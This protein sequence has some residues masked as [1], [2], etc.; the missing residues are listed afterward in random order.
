MAA[1]FEAQVDRDAEQVACRFRGASLTYGELDRRANQLAR[2]LRALGVRDESCV[3]VHLE[4]SLAAVVAIVAVVKAGGAYVPLDPEHPA[5]RCAFTIRDSGA[6]VVVT[7]RSLWRGAAVPD[8]PAV[9]WLD[10]AD[11]GLAAESPERLPLVATPESLAYVI[12][13]SGSTGAPKGV[14]VTHRNA[15]RL[16][17]AT[18]AWFGFGAADVW[19]LF[20]SLAFDFSVWELWG[21][22][23]YGGTVVI[24]PFEVSRSPRQMARLLAEEGVTVLNQTPSAFR[25][26]SPALLAEGGPLALRTIIFGGEALDYRA[27]R[28]WVARHGDQTPRLVNMYGITE[29]TVHVTY[30]P[31]LAGDVAADTPSCIGAPIPDLELLLLD[32]HLAPVADGEPGEIFVAGPGVARGYLNRP[33]LT[34]ERF[35]EWNGRRV[36]RSGDRARRLAD[37]DLEYL[38]RGD[39]Q[40]KLRGFRIETGEIAARLGEVEGVRE[41]VVRLVGAGDAARLVAY[42]VL[43]DGHELDRAAARRRLRT[44]LPDPMIP[45]AFV[46]LRAWPL[47]ING[48]LDVAALPLPERE[49]GE[50]RPPTGETARTIAALWREVLGVEQVGLG[51]D[52]VAL[53][54]ASLAAAEVAA[55]IA[56]ALGVA[57]SLRQV[58]EHTRLE[59]L[60][61]F[62]EAQARPAASPADGATAPAATDE[63]SAAEQAFF[64]M[65]QRAPGLALYAESL[66]WRWRGPFD[67]AL[68]RE[69]LDELARRHPIL[70]TTFVMAADGPRR[71]IAAESSVELTAHDLTHLEASQREAHARSAAAIRLRDGFDLE[72]GPLWR[73]LV[74]SAADEAPTIFILFHH[75]ILD[76]VACAELVTQLDA[77]YRALRAGV[78]L[79]PPPRVRS[80]AGEAA[81]DLPFWRAQL[82]DLPELEVPTDRSRPLVPSFRGGKVSRVVPAALAHEVRALSRQAGVTPFTTLLAAFELLL[83]RLC[84]A[85]EV[86][87]GVIAAGRVQRGGALGCF[88]NPLVVRQELARDEPFRELLGRAR[89]TLLDAQ[90][91]PSL[92]FARLVGE[93]GASRID[94]RNPLFQVAFSADVPMPA[95]ATAAGFE[96]GPLDP[97]TARFDLAVH[98]EER[99]DTFA[100][101]AEYASDLFDEVTVARWLERYV[102]VLEGVARE[103]SVRVGAVEI[104]G[105]REKD[106]LARFAAGP[107]APNGPG[108]PERLRDL[109]RES[110][111]AL[112]VVSGAA[113]LTYGELAARAERIAGH[114][115]S[116][117]VE[118]DEL[119]GLY[120]RPN[121]EWVAAVFGIWRAGAAYVPLDPRHPAERIGTTLADAGVRR[122]ITIE[123]A[124]SALTRFD[125]HVL[126][127]E[128]LVADPPRAAVA[129]SDSRGR[130]AYV[131]YTSGSTGTPKGALVGHDN[132]ANFCDGFV[133]LF[134]A[135]PGDRVAQLNSPAFDASVLE[136]LLALTTG[137]TLVIAP[138]EARIP[139]AE[140][141]EFLAGQG[142]SLAF[143]APALFGALP[144]AQP[145]SALPRLRHVLFGGDVLSRELVERWAPGRTVWNAY[146][147]TETTVIT[148]ATRVRADGSRPPIGRP[149]AGMRAHVVDE[150]LRPCPIGVAGELVIGGAGVGRGY[151]RRPELTQ[152]RFL[153]DPFAADAGARIYRSGDLVRL[154]SDGQIEFLSRLDRQVKLRGNRIELG[155]IESVLVGSP[156]VAQAVVVARVDQG[157]MRLVAYVVGQG[158]PIDPS[159][160]RARLRER[161]PEFMVPAAF[162]ELERLPLNTSGKLDLMAL[163]SPSAAPAPRVE[164]A[165]RAPRDERLEPVIA[166]L[167]GE[168]LGLAA[169]PVDVPFFEL[170]GNSL[171]LVRVQTGLRERF[172]R[173]VSAVQLLALPTVQAIAGHLR[174]L[175]VDDAPRAIGSSARSA[176]PAPAARSNAIAIVGRFVR[177]PG[178]ETLA[179]LWRIVA[180]GRDVIEPFA[181]GEV[182]A[183]GEHPHFVAAE[184][185]LDGANAF[186]AEFFGMTPADARLMD[187]QHRVFLEAAWASLEDAGHDPRRFAGRIGVF[188]G[189]GVPRHWLGPIG[190]ALREDP[191]AALADRAELF[192]LPEHLTSRTAFKLGLRGPA[193]TVHAACATSLVAVHMACRSLLA[194][195]CEMALAGGV[196]ISTVAPSERGYMA[197][198]GGIFSPTGRCRPFSLDADGTVKASGVGVVVLRRLEDAI[199]AGDA[200]AGVILGSAVNNDGGASVGFS[201]PAEAG[202][203]AVLTEAYRAA[204]VAPTEVDLVEAHGTGTALGDATEVSALRRVFGATRTAE[205]VSLGSVK[206][207]LGHLDS[208]AGVVGLIKATLALEHR[209][210]PGLPEFRG[211][212]PLLEIDA[213]P[214]V[215]HGEPRPLVRRGRP[216][217]AGVT[218][219]GMGGNNAHVVV[220]EAPVTAAQPAARDTA[221]L[222]CL[223]ARTPAALDAMTRRLA[224]HLR[225]EPRASVDDVAFTLATGRAELPL[226]RAV[227]V[228]A[229]ED[230][231]AALADRRAWIDGSAAGGRPVVFLFPGH[232]AQTVG[233]GLDLYRSEPRYREVVDRCLAL[234]RDGA[235]VDLGP[236]LLTRDASRQA[237]F[238]EPR[239]GQLG[240]FVVG[241]ALA[242]LLRGW[243]VAPAALLGHSLGEYVAACVAG[244]FSL[245]DALALV[246]ARARLM[247]GCGPGTMVSI[248]AERADVAPI[249]PASVS[250][251]TEAPGCTVI[252]GPVEAVAAVEARLLARGFEATRLPVTQAYHSPMMAPI[253]EA[254]LARVAAVQR[255]PPSLPVLSCVTGEWLTD[256]A[257][258]DP[259][260]WADHLCG[261]VTLTGALGTLLADPARV[262]VE[263]GPGRSMRGFLRRHP[264]AGES[265]VTVTTLRHASEPE[266]ADDAHLLAGVGRL[267]AHGVALDWPAVHARRSARRVPLPTY[268]FERRVHMIDQS[269]MIQ[270]PARA[271]VFSLAGER[272]ALELQAS[273]LERELGVRTLD[274]RPGVREG[275]EAVALALVGRYFVEHG[276]ARPGER[277]RVAALQDRLGVLPRFERMFAFLLA[278]SHARG[279]CEVDAGAVIWRELPSAA[280]AE[281][282]FLRRHPEFAGLVR[283]VAHAVGHYHA[284]FRGEVESIGVLYPDGS[285]AFYR[286]CMRASAPISS[287]ELCLRLARSVAVSLVNSRSEPTRILEVG[288][289]HG[290]LTWPLI[291]ELV[292]CVARGRRVDYSFT[293]IGRSFLARA[294][295]RAAERGAAFVRTGRYDLDREPASQG[296]AP[297]SFDLIL[298]FNAVHTARDTAATVA[299]LHELLAPRGLLVLV[300]ATRVE[301]WETL[302]WGLAPGFWDVMERGRESLLHRAEDW[303]DFTRRAGFAVTELLPRAGRGRHD[304]A[305]VVAQRAAVQASL[306][307]SEASRV[308]PANRPQVAARPDTNGAAVQ[309]AEAV[310]AKIFHRLLGTRDVAPDASF[311]ALGGDSLLAVQLLAEV[312]VGLGA[313]VRSSEFAQAPTIAGLTRLVAPRLPATG[314]RAATRTEA[315]GSEARL[316]GAERGTS[317][318]E[319]VSLAARLPRALAAT[320]RDDASLVARSLRAEHATA[321]DDAS[322]AA[323]SPHVVQAT[324]RHDASLAARSPHVVQATTRHDASLAARSP[325]VVQA[326]TRHDAS[327][328]ARSPHVVHATTRIDAPSFEAHLPPA[329]VPLQTRGDKPPFFCVHGIGGSA[330]G[331]APLAGRLGDEQPFYA[332]QASTGDAAPASLSALAADH[333]AAI[334][335][336]QPAGPYRVGGWSFGA[337]VAQEMARQLEAAGERVTHLVLFDA[338]A[339]KW[340]SPLGAM[341]GRWSLAGAMVRN[342]RLQGARAGSRWRVADVLR[343]SANVVETTAEFWD[344]SERHVRLLRAHQP[345]A[346][347]APITHFRAREG[348]AG[349]ELPFP[350]GGPVEVCEVPGDHFTM[351]SDASA[352][353]ALA[354]RLAQCLDTVRPDDRARE[355]ADEE[356]AICELMRRFMD[357]SCNADAGSDVVDAFFAR[358]AETLLF[359]SYDGTFRGFAAIREQYARE[360]E[361]MIDATVGL[362][363]EFVRIA[364]GGRSAFLT[365]LVDSELKL[366]RSGR[367]IR[368]AR[369]RLTAVLEK[370]GADWRVVHV[371]YSLPV[372]VPLSMMD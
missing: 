107:P 128:R 308:A 266:I 53:G 63:L 252:S 321:Q 259:A 52:F 239:L 111:D 306:R 297:G 284:A 355:L 81:D 7:E 340:T 37:G 268:P 339:R 294:E 276:G 168:I 31:V 54:G 166:G 127:C 80:G 352:V 290:I 121:A 56:D 4:R 27:L 6:V 333:V 64:V 89:A 48:K 335:R 203:V 289:G 90:A 9:V 144:V 286:E 25:A 315:S 314:G 216:L 353:R 79:P 60:A 74:F 228:G 177:G 190:D 43:H 369:V 260:Y 29:T 223:S 350:L 227:V 10:D 117:G 281:A 334:R 206:A 142:I 330:A 271:E 176:P 101:H 322:L 70:R 224:E 61:E 359:D 148:T 338:P 173:T 36:Y 254:F 69:A 243:G 324:T 179:D 73:V 23:L 124:S 35:F 349:G 138:A 169:V 149:I 217:R 292:G 233:M 296:F 75:I 263:V 45:A 329:L 62:V 293:D 347:R 261:T 165:A 2:R 172:G 242:S 39:A 86:V 77:I 129:S 195:D 277:V 244:V 282:G 38:G 300:E 181:P 192:N 34:R 141:V 323:R 269:T 285:D 187:P 234:L 318:S 348:L 370:H 248:L 143:G 307:P 215:V 185:R 40:V 267:W 85:R 273:R 245:A 272:D 255:R 287:D 100:F 97:G 13:T 123:D 213:S 220:E 47:T 178:V 82:A 214:F 116:L 15:A 17:A 14:M 313:E 18:N 207:N 99:G 41:A 139:G 208:A 344:M 345:G 193:V 156:G 49:A 372:G 366:R 33:E 221:A 137:A 332:L 3:A 50:H 288:A 309:A 126:A 316:S 67:D 302:V 162:V 279:L 194:G 11:L 57:L 151:L 310:I 55:R 201:A 174:S 319:V 360:F 343:R 231:S 110:P 210:A 200:I 26:L 303:A 102:T 351:F 199:A 249:L 205:P 150:A 196:S 305:L 65:A 240:T 112:A 198:P 131:I 87:L 171:G 167:W 331:Y 275:L 78:A 161:L 130:L 327:L 66:L 119:V 68:W 312:R 342:A 154:R 241:Y 184:G 30:R 361:A 133:S 12:Y 304:H 114:L 358:D 136:L 122:V 96:V 183:R 354:D 59:D 95:L 71:R 257:A 325:H 115:A 202:Q 88:M 51:D 84:G 363:E 365:G 337:I 44:V 317:R 42:C 147:P 135:G 235:G 265:T 222:L 189:V 76:G 188:A 118:P 20:H 225:R 152:E 109:A 22:L 274:E 46:V 356:R 159:R 83:H 270:A 320:T 132:L 258:V 301:L 328:A 364:P 246:D 1:G 24:V 218:S 204:G 211:P 153:P 5:E 367:P 191:D 108:V 175:G 106:E 113:R 278:T 16:F 72:R 94:G 219:L 237:A 238:A 362:Y 146:G 180:D 28:P 250:V 236:Y 197:L 212:N 256:A 158:A 145:A 311:F 341:V 157:E 247:E 371:H 120:G 283:F 103:P 160:L 368:F 170:G 8:G 19:A 298:G 182:G 295:A 140:M 262:F 92:P 186:D 346:V 98:V 264:L 336:V 125:G 104:L 155:E 226:R 93:L 229:R 134:G 105:A 299:R 232:G 253:R 164:A 91:H 326:T 58:L 357:L 280:E 230:A 291:D 251:A 209:V 21:A 32:E 163:P